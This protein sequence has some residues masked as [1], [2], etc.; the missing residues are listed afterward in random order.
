M[1]KNR[2]SIVSFSLIIFVNLMLGCENGIKDAK[3]TQ[4]KSFSKEAIT[5]STESSSNKNDIHVNDKNLN[6][7]ESNKENSI[8]NVDM[9]ELKSELERIYNER[10]TALVS[11]DIASLNALFDTSQKYGQLA[12]EHEIKRVKYLND[13]SSERNITFGTIGSSVSIKKVYPQDNI[14]KVYLHESYK[15]DYVYDKDINSPIDSFRIGIRHT[16]SLI[17]KNEKWVIYSD[18]YTDCFEDA[19]HRYTNVVAKLPE[20]PS[21]VHNTNNNYQTVNYCKVFYDRQKAVYYAD[22]YCGAAFETN[23]DLKY[24]EKYNDY[25]GR[26]GDCTNYISQVLADKEG[27]GMPLGGIWTPSSKTWVNAN[28]LK[29]YLI[30]SGKGT[31]INVGT[32]KELTKPSKTSAKGIIGNLQIGDLIAYE[33]GPNNIDH[34][35]VITGFDSHGYPLVNSHTTDR[36]HVPWDL[37]WGDA[38]IRFF[39]IHIN[40]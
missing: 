37:G 34:F 11:G 35:A 26:G 18:R 17:K 14:L 1:I 6:Q 2:I 23:N 12:L 5:D 40:G 36:Y 29:N 28:S 16:T 3:D 13:W 21:S 20:K 4:Q 8:N 38:K 30:N 7:V 33:K 32:F 39:L 10:S 31:V 9:N 22:K 27:G 25:N 15:F 24:N 19:L